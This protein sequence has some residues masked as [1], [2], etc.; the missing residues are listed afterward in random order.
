MPCHIPCDATLHQQPRY[1]MPIYVMTQYRSSRDLYRH[2]TSN[3]ICTVQATSKLSPFSFPSTQS[4]PTFPSPVPCVKSWHNSVTHSTASQT[5]LPLNLHRL[6][7]ST[8]SHSTTSQTPLRH[9][10]SSTA[11]SGNRIV[12]CVATATGVPG[13]SI[14][15]GVKILDAF[16]GVA[17]DVPVPLP[18]P[19][20]SLIT[21]PPIQ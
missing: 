15:P 18:V 11:S 12:L 13:R 14:S 6:P 21:V 17:G 3:I 20:P 8:A 1:A 2:W 4:L 5:P 9:F 7:T 19:P 16:P 10:V